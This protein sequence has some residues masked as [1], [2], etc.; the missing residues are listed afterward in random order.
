MLDS[1]ELLVLSSLDQ[2]NSI[3]LLYLVLVEGGIQ[4]RHSGFLAKALMFYSIRVSTNL[5]DF[6]VRGLMISEQFGGDFPLLKQPEH[7]ET[8]LRM[9]LFTELEL[10]KEVLSLLITQCIEA[11]R[12]QVIRALISLNS[13]GKPRRLR[14]VSLN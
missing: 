1:S 2:L 12:W 10:V 9:D 14:W 8:P 5:L 7:N 11:L 13:P 4:G 3:Y 6:G